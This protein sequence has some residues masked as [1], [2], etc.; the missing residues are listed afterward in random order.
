MIRE[1]CLD[2]NYASIHSITPNSGAGKSKFN[3]ENIDIYDR[4]RFNFNG[5]MEL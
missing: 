5:K 1:L 3:R 4:F 2:G